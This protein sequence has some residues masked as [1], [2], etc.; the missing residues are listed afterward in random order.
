MRQVCDGPGTLRSRLR[1]LWRTMPQ[2]HLTTNRWIRIGAVGAFAIVLG[3]HPAQA[4]SDPPGGLGFVTIGDPGNAP[5][6][7]GP[8]GQ[9][10]GVGQVNYEYRMGRTEVTTSQWLDFVNAVDSFNPVLARDT[11]EPSV[12]GAH[13]VGGAPGTG[14]WMLD[15]QQQA[16]MTAVGG[17]S[18]RSAA[19]YCNWLHNGQAPTPYAISSGAYDTSTFTTNP[20]GSFNDQLTRSPGARYWIPSTDEWIK[21]AHY[22][23]NRDGHGQG[24]WWTFPYQSESVPISGMPGTPG[25]QTS[26]EVLGSPDLWYEIPLNSY[27]DAM[28]AYGLLDVSGG[29]KEW[30]E[31]S[32]AKAPYFDRVFE[33]SSISL[34]PGAVLFDAAWTPSGSTRPM[35]HRPD[36]GLRIASMVPTP[37]A[38]VVLA[39]GLFQVFRRKR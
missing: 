39:L 22:D 10:A 15:P 34:Y 16:A 36:V 28:T 2:I 12:W 20:D 1:L 35:N 21:A 37:G 6:P 4:S 9:R 14:R 18:W 11:L 30:T 13:Y 17:M 8:S 29:A 5:Y 19:M 31:A 23:P 26:V 32:Q 24:G 38:C 25:A 27:P 33:G 3:A 7:G